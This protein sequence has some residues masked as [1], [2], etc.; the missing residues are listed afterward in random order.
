M[1]PFVLFFLSLF[2]SLAVSAKQ[3]EGLYKAKVLVPNQSQQSHL[4]G[5]KAGLMEVLHKVT[6]YEAPIEHPVVARALGIADQYLYQFSFTRIDQSDKDAGVDVGSSWMNMQFEGKSIQR[7][8]RQAKLPRWGSNRPTVMVWM[9]LDD[10]QRQIMTDGLEHSGVKALERAAG[11]RGL[12]LILPVYDLE[13]SMKLPLEQL[14]GLFSGQ[15]QNASE[16][17]GAESVLAVRVFETEPGT[18][19]GHWRFYFRDKEYEFH[20]SGTKM[21][22]VVLLGLTT[23]AG[24]LAD[25]FALKPSEEKQG[26][27][28]IN[29][30]RINS[31]EHYAD[32]TKYLKKL[33]ITK[34]VS[35]LKAKGSTLIL[36]LELNGSLSQ[37]KQTL[38]LNKKLVAKKD[39][40]TPS[41][42]LL[43]E[44]QHPVFVW[45]P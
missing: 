40:E 3:V 30:E 19:V 43:S 23:S 42:D 25:A 1:K 36:E 41:E 20:Y 39:P 28:T 7:I 38:A 44:D 31:L 8:V 45:Q 2:V 35:L 37:F 15:I 34:N 21:E 33:A 32:V 13:D 24:I 16:R 22:D 27:L 14:W 12:P 11:Q 6:G 5:A 4:S 29:V 17:Y 10:G 9:A 18:W 26:V